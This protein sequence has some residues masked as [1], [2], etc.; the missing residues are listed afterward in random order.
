MR[1]T[2]N[3]SAWALL[4][5]GGAHVDR[6][7]HVSG[8]FHAGASN[9]GRLTASVGGGALNGLRNAR[10]AGVDPVALVSA[11]GGDH[12]EAIVAD[13]IDGAGI[14]DLSAVFLDRRSA[15]YTAILDETGEQVAGLADMDIY[16]TAL[17]RQLRRKALREAISNARAVLVDANLPVPAL[18]AVAGLKTGALF[19]IAISPAKAPRLAGIAGT[20]DT[21]FLNRRELAVLSGHEADVRGLGA[22]AA[23]GFRS[24]VVT[25]GGEPVLVLDGN[26]RHEV[27]PPPLSEI[28][29]VTGAGD[30]LAGATIA[31]LL[32]DPAISLA[33]AVRSGI[34]AAQ[35][36]LRAEGPVAASLSG[37]DFDAIRDVCLVRALQT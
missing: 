31:A 24:A 26:E 15:S 6:I 34:A 19:A 5:V 20:I 9:P 12:D 2:D 28:A 32:D 23:L 18:E 14:F 10:L 1:D 11:R 30:A 17:P 13:A 36:T 33:E 29:D 4:G 7:G 35:L 3:K 22:L 21:V 37:P 8:P 16:E 27:V 25:G